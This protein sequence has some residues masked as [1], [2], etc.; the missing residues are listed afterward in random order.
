MPSPTSDNGVSTVLE[1]GSN[2]PSESEGLPRVN[3]GISLAPMD[4]LVASVNK[5]LRNCEYCVG[6]SLVLNFDRSIGFAYN[7]SIYCDSCKQK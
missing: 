2:E 1:G 3:A 5:H 4:Q 6:S 7:Y